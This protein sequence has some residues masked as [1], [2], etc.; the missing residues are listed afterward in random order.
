MSA[1]SR[2]LV[3][4]LQ[5]ALL[6][7]EL[8]RPIMRA[9]RLTEQSLR[10]M[11]DPKDAPYTYNALWSLRWQSKRPPGH[12]KM[13]L[14]LLLHPRRV[15]VYFSRMLKRVVWMITSSMLKLTTR[16]V[17]SYA[18]KALLEIPRIDRIEPVQ[19]RRELLARKRRV[20]VMGERP[21]GLRMMNG[22]KL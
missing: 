21:G 15:F 18:R 19:L 3:R 8:R 7:L 13:L 11:Q 2:S 10:R 14:S 22:L 9:Q 6:L 5:I 12:L 1:L 4:C 20:S 17:K 16:I